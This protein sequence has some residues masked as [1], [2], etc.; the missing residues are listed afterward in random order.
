MAKDQ[1]TGKAVDPATDL[2]DF[3]GNGVYG[4]PEFVWNTPI[5]PTALKFLNSD[6]LCKPYQNTIFVG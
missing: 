4:D 6:K 5:G 3:A 1:L 2:V